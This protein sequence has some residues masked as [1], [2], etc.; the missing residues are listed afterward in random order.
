MLFSTLINRLPPSFLDKIN[1]SISSLECNVLCIV[2]SF[3]LLG[4]ICWSSLVHFRNGLM[5][6]TSGYNPGV[7]LFD[8]T[9]V[10][11][12]E[13]FSRS[14]V[15]HFLKDFLSSPLVWWCPLL[16]IP[17]IRKFP[18]PVN[19]LTFSWFGSSIPSVTCRFLVP[20]ISMACFSTL[21][22]IPIVILSSTAS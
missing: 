17:S 21:N 19:V 20:I 9:V 7:N 14:P 10:F 15:I 13:K 18:F 1:L 5:Y 12:F 4:S 6:L 22:S 2:I 11:S 8:E 16:I 3:L